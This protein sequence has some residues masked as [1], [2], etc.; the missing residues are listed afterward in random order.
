MVSSYHVA[1]DNLSEEI[2]WEGDVSY[3]GEIVEISFSK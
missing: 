1:V 3:H 2:R